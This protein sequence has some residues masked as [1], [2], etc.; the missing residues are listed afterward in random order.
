[1][2]QTRPLEHRCQR[3][4]SLAIANWID[5]PLSRYGIRCLVPPPLFDRLLIGSSA[6]GA[7]NFARTDQAGQPP[8]PQ[9]PFRVSL[10]LRVPSLRGELGSRSSRRRLR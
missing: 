5:P 2:H 1:M 4:P 6:A 7:A 10:H 3:P 8:P 9:L